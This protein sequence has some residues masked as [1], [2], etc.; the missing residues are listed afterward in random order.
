MLRLG[1]WDWKSQSP[2]PGPAPTPAWA[3]PACRGCNRPSSSSSQSVFSS[4]GVSGGGVLGG[5]G[6][7]QERPCRSDPPPSPN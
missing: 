2:C 1:T 6:Q 7:R 3:S 4:R 5:H